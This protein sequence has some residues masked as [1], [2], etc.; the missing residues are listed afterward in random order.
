M[1]LTLNLSPDKEEALKTQAQNHGLT[2]EAWL[3]ELAERALPEPRTKQKFE[4]LSDLLLNS[5]FAGSNLSL[6][7][8]QDMPRSVNVK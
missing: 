7:R 5:P 3:L 2:V 8:A 1:T 6:D 4:N